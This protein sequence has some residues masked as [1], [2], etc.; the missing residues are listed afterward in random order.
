M[1]LGLALVI[2]A[3]AYVAAWVLGLAY[4]VAPILSISF[5]GLAA[6]TVWNIATIILFIVPLTLPF[7]FWAIGAV[8]GMLMIMALDD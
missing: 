7:L 8:F 1:A 6:L 2:A 4:Y 3:L 5:G